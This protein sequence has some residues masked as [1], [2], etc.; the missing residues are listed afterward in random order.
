MDRDAALEAFQAARAQCEQ[1]FARVPA[2]ALSYVK[3]GDE[4]SLG[5][6]QLHVNW[7]L[8]KYSRV[9][10]AILAFRFQRVLGPQHPPGAEARAHEAAGRPL[11]PAERERA[12]AEM[13]RLHD[14][15]FATCRSMPEEDWPRQAQVVYEAGR[16]P[17][18]TS[19]QDIVAWLT[20]H[21]REHAAQ[22]AALIDC[23]K[24][25]EAKPA[26]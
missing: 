7:T 17:D 25:A 5:G 14:Q 20:D 9:L 6:L 16:D 4:Y 23:W 1:A 18:P 3:P 11:A 22:C 2:G 19:P 21:Y 13:A 8:Q 26:G 10:S 15:V 12:V 24:D